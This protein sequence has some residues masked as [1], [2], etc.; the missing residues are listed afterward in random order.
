MQRTVR[1]GGDDGELVAVTCRDCG[2]V[3]MPMP[4][5]VG[6]TGRRALPPGVP[7]MARVPR[8]AVGMDPEGLTGVQLRPLRVRRLGAAYWLKAPPP[9]VFTRCVHRAREVP[10][11]NV[12]QKEQT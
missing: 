5:Q 3:G 2:T 4:E 6:E 12:R 8:P 1:R 7:A 9:S 10:P 11:S